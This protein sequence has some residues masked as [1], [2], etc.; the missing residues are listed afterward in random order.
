MF[1]DK[2]KLKIYVDYIDLGFWVWGIRISGQIEDYM[3]MEVIEVIQ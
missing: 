1:A 3:L 2:K